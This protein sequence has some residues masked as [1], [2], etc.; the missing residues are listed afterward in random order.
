MRRYA[1]LV[2]IIGLSAAMI[3]S[4]ACIHK[5]TP[6]TPWER[7]TTENAVLAQLINTAT[8][9]TIAVQASGLVT[10][11]Q[12]EPVIAFEGQAASVQQQINA[13]LAVA[14][15]ATGLSQLQPLIA[16]L[17]ASAQALVSSGA[18]GVKDPKTQQTVN[19]DIQAIVTSAEAILASYQLAV[20]GN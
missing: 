7:V 9:G 19:A 14:P 18:L 6:V 12:I 3:G 2:L 4:V 20:G 17:Q 5:A 16:Q 1:P 13:I 11:A 8:Q 10:V 15:S